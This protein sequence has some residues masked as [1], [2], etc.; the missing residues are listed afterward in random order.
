MS[1][2]SDIED[3]I[4]EWLFKEFNG[5]MHKTI[6]LDGRWVVFDVENPE[7][8]LVEIHPAEVVHQKEPTFA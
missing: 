3:A 2:Q 8:V 4:N 5:N 6:W 7:C 1:L